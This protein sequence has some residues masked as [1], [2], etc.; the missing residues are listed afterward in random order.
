MIRLKRFVFIILGL[1]LSSVVYSQYIGWGIK[2]IGRNVK[3]ECECNIEIN[4]KDDD[5][6]IIQFSN[7]L[8][9]TEMIF[10]ME[11]NDKC[12]GYSVYCDNNFEK[13]LRDFIELNYEYVKEEDFYENR[14]SYLFYQSDKKKKI[15]HVITKKASSKKA[16]PF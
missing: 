7:E 4:K 15:I 13:K 1:T 9:V 10:Y 6:Y 3:W 14:R 12:Y 2:R 8:G 5:K 11:E 16:K